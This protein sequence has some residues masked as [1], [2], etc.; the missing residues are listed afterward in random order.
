MSFRSFTLLDKEEA[1]Y[2]PLNRIPIHTYRGVVR[3]IFRTDGIVVM[4][5]VSRKTSGTALLKKVHQGSVSKDKDAAL[6]LL[7]FLEV[8]TGWAF[9]RVAKN[10]YCDAYERIDYIRREH[11]VLI[12]KL[13]DDGYFIQKKRRASGFRSP[14]SS[15]P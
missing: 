2:T 15:R 12:E 5:V 14:T 8:I 10:D 13:R 3:V 6:I 1:V 7:A 4:E 9:C 11:P